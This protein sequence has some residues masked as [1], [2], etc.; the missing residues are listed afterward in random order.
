M[1]TKHSRTGMDL[2]SYTPAAH[3]GLIALRSA[4]NNRPFNAVLD[5]DYI[6]EVQM[7]RPGAVLPSPITVSRDINLIYTEMSRKVKE[8]FMVCYFCT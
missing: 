2:I 7:L 4:K 1:A 6:R 5:E 3:R 8:Y